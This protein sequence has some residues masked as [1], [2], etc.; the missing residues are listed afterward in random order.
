M[1]C[2]VTNWPLLVVVITVEIALMKGAH[3]MLGEA[4]RILEKHHDRRVLARSNIEANEI[5][6]RLATL[7]EAMD[8][9][10]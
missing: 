3:T 4:E 7:F 9:W 8:T 10:R 2:W 1:R 6:P 5:L